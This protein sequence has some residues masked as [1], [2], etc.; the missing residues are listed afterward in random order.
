MDALAGDGD[1]GLEHAAQL[2]GHILV[3]DAGPLD[4]I[5]GDGH[6]AVDV[7]AGIQAGIFVGFDGCLVHQ[8][9]VRDLGLSGRKLV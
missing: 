8:L 4:E 2:V 5:L 6:K 9:L 7:A 1:V 3:K